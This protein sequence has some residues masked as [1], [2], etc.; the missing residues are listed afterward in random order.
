[1]NKY[2]I[3]NWK[4]NPT[5]KKEAK[6]LFDS[7]SKKISQQKGIEVAV[8]P[9]F[10]YLSYFPQKGIIKL[11]AQ[12]CFWEEKGLYTGEIS[13]L[14]LKDLGCKYVIVGHSERRQYQIET[15]YIVNR[16]IKAVL[17]SGM[18][19]IMCIEKDSQITGGLKGLSNN[20]IKKVIIAFEPIGAI[21]TGK[22]YDVE[23]AKRMKD[24]IKRKVKMEI[25]VLYGGSINSSNAKDY[26]VEAG[27]DGLLIGGASLKSD[28]FSRIIKSLI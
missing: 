5:N 8:C 26:V 19:P 14:Q 16:K 12:N 9:P 24:L 22:A 10:V 13:S 11:G 20:D 21:G 25:P 28:E 1:M 6:N 2:I 23:A 3:G 18:V 4:C 7:L 15:D 27:F 17:A